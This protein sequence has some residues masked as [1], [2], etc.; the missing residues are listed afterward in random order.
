MREGYPPLEQPPWK[1]YTY[2]TVLKREMDCLRK[3]WTQ[4]FYLASEQKF[5]AH[6]LFEEEEG[7][8]YCCPHCHKMECKVGL[9]MIN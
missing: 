6:H 8:Y 1:E 2:I 7:N 3:N 4:L 5:I 9:A